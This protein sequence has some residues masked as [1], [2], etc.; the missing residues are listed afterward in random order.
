MT[1]GKGEGANCREPTTRKKQIIA[2]PQNYPYNRITNIQIRGGGD[3]ET[4]SNS[5]AKD[6]KSNGKVHGGRV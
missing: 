3:V 4:E 6:I 2:A 1:Q 5:R